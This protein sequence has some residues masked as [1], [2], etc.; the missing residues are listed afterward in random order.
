M[1]LSK[2]LSLS[3]WTL[4]TAF[5]T[6]VLQLVLYYYI[7]RTVQPEQLGHYFLAAALI[8]IPAGILEYSFVSSLI[9]ATQAGPQDYKSVF[10]I[11]IK[12]AL[13]SA[14]VGLLIAGLMSLYYE[15]GDLLGY[16]VWLMPILFF[17]SYSSVQNAG[18]KKELLIRTFSEIELSAFMMYV[19]VTAFL[20]YLGK[21]VAALIYGQLA[22]AVAAAVLLRWRAA[23]LQLGTKSSKEKTAQHWSYG[24]YI[25]G[26]KSLGIGMSYL[27]VFLIHHFLGAQVLGIYDLLKRMVLRPLISAYNALEQ[28]VFP[29]LSKAS[30]EPEAFRKVYISLIKLS[31]VFLL[32]SLGL[33][34]VEP[35][36]SFFPESYADYDTV[37]RLIIVLAISIIIFNPVDILAYSLDLTQKYFNWIIIYSVVQIVVMLISL[38]A[39]LEPFLYAMIS[40]NLVVY[41]LSFFVLFKSST[42]ITFWDWAKPGLALVMVI[43][44]CL[45]LGIT[46]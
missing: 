10:D 43:L 3:K 27:D 36:L 28:V 31:G 39:G 41:L 4:A 21:G 32:A 9:Q 1:S 23:Y 38:A 14:A 37:L 29:M 42:V 6:L 18:L 46:W 19:I 44:L 22:K 26:E 24:K 20:L 40:F 16:Y 34:F 12:L 25:M 8:F 17:I 7:A 30:A 33:F 15:K 2:I 5:I 13:L 11:N 35:I 45:G